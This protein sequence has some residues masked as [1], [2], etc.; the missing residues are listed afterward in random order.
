LLPNGQYEVLNEYLDITFETLTDPSRLTKKHDLSDVT[1]K[2]GTMVQELMRT[3]PVDE[4]GPVPVPVPV[5]PTMV[6]EPSSIRPR[7]PPKNA[8][9]KHIH[10]HSTRYSQKQ[11]GGTYD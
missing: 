6:I 11:R 3:V 4:K 8:S 2:L 1:S 7:H 9:F 5:P 10:H